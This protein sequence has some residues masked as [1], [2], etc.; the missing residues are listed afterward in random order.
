MSVFT[1]CDITV[2]NF[3]INLPVKT[4]SHVKVTRLV[5]KMRGYLGRIPYIRLPHPFLCPSACTVGRGS[6]A[7]SLS[8]GGKRA[9]SEL[10]Y[11]TPGCLPQACSLFHLKF[12]VVTGWHSIHSPAKFKQS[13]PSFC[14]IRLGVEIECQGKSLSR[15]LCLPFLNVLK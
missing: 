2:E 9:G 11:L 4:Y 14:S 3:M 10:Y 6:C 5:I 15:S 1:T 7:E 8:V 13:L 12:L